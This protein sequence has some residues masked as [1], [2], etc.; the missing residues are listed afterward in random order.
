MRSGQLI[1]VAV[2][3]LFTFFAYAEPSDVLLLKNEHIEVELRSSDGTWNTVRMARATGGDSLEISSDEFEILLFDDSR[4][5]VDDY[6]VGGEAKISIEEGKQIVRISYKRKAATSPKAPETVEVVYELGGGAYFHKGLFIPMEEGD[7]I[8]RLQVARFSTSA[9]ASRGGFGEAIFINNWFFGVD[10]PGF[11]SR[12]SDGFKEPDYYYRWFYDI[13]LDGRDAEF[14]PREGLVTLFHFPGYAQKQSDGQWG[15]S[16]KRFVAGLSPKKGENAELALLDY[17]SKTRKKPRSFLHYNNW[18]SPEAKAV[19]VETFVNKVYKSLKENLGKYGVELDAMVP[20]HG[21][22]NSKTF[23]SILEPKLDEDHDPLTEISE[24]LRK[25][26]TE[27]GI[28]YAIDGTNQ[29]TEHGLEIGYAPA[30]VEGFDR[31]KRWM[32]GKAYFDILDPKYISDLKKSLRFLLVDVKVNYIKH[33]FNH[34]FTS[35][36]MTQRHAREK[37]L[38]TTLELLEYE[39]GLNAEV[40]QNYT[41]GAW[42]SPWWL[43]F[44]DTIWMMSGDSGGSGDWPQ[45]SLR[46]GATTYRDKYFFE[47]FNNPERC[48]RP[49]LPI[50]NFMTHGILFSTRKPFTDFKDTLHDW[51]NYVVMYFARG[52]MLKEL[53][54]TPELLDDDHWKVL[55]MACNWAVRNQDRLVNTV[56]IGGDASKG[57]VYGYISW[58]DGRAILTVRNPDRREQTLTIPFD[59]T[60]YYRGEKRTA[61]SA[62]AVYP[63]VEQMPWKLVSGNDFLVKV[64]GDSVIVYELE[65]GEP[66]S[67]IEKA[68]QPLPPFKSKIEMTSFELEIIVPDEEMKRYDL[69]IQ[70]W[71][72]VGVALTVNGQAVEPTK[73]V[74]AKQWTLYAFNLREYRGRTLNIQA[75]ITAGKYETPP[76]NSEVA[77]Q[78]WLV[79]GR[80]IDAEAKRQD[81]NLPFA[82]SQNYRRIS[83]ELVPRT[84]F[85]I[86]PGKRSSS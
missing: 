38:D 65:P 45:L 31:S 6:E 13:D 12:H 37:C 76:K 75:K 56:L 9:K 7:K 3:C 21:W 81:R 84:T 24:A 33:D 54:I 30:Y 60:V 85:Q 70:P 39:L 34:N 77:L 62:R 80:R 2:F 36:Y 57:E 72:K 49:V 78:A 48:I 64:P 47:S 5:T 83:Q 68:P 43:Q 23:K 19:T 1:T 66:K 55:G 71:G 11:Y 15:I 17:I 73:A 61:Y 22:E 51:S 44:A 63:F 29:S 69:L 16:S 25:N 27:L 20:D 52:T 26:G 67:G 58:V 42:F 79:A 28:W 8:D 41:N 46:E 4:F 14:S 10:Y 35:N 86:E 74:E 40:F 59:Q 82:I 18:Y 32:Q 50:A 53:Y